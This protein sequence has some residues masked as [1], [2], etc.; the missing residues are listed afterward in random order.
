MVAYQLRAKTSINKVFSF[1]ECHPKCACNKDLCQNYLVAAQNKKRWSLMVKRLQ[2]QLSPIYAQEMLSSKK[3]ANQA[4]PNGKNSSGP[5][6][7][8]SQRPA[9]ICMWGLVAMEDIP[10]GAFLMEYQGEIV[11]KKQGDMRGTYYDSNGLSYLFD[12]N[13]PSEGEEREKL[14]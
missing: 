13:D 8:V 9:S 12:M 7:V 11:T 2:K 14:I 10:A 1:N 5:S 6:S 3:N 4:S